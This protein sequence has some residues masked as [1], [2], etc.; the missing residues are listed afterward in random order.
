MFEFFDMIAG[1]LE[2]IGDLIVSVFE[3][4]L[5]SVEILETLVL[6]PITLLGYMPNI[7]ASAVMLTLL[8]FVVK[9][10]IGR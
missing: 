6:V 5:T 7:L 9:F 2:L 10:F 8:I 1:W 4:L 3:M